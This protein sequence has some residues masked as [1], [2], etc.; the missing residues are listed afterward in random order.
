ML[1][2]HSILI[3]GVLLSIA[4]MTFFAP[5]NVFPAGSYGTRSAITAAQT[6]QTKQ[7]GDLFVTLQVSPGCVNTVNRVTVT[8]SDASDRRIT[9]ARVVLTT[10]MESMDMGRASRALQG[11]NLTYVATFDGRIAF[12]MFGVW[13]IAVGIARPGHA[14]SGAGAVPNHAN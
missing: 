1:R 8:L 5:P 12:S 4:M 9:D 2:A 7:V 10:S 3:A 13:D 6:A 11:D 14:P